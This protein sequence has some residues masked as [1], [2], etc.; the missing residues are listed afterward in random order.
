[1]FKNFFEEKARKFFRCMNCSAERF[2]NSYILVSK[3]GR[4]LKLNIT[5]GKV[6]CHV[7]DGG[8]YW[9]V[10]TIP[11]YDW[12]ID[13][14]LAYIVYFF[15]YVFVKHPNLRWLQIRLRVECF[16]K[17][18]AHFYGLNGPNVFWENMKTS[19]VVYK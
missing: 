4:Y 18:V 9:T 10:G 16:E 12:N 19:G 7:V 13:W 14:M 2:E 1:M 15:D 17:R 11:F 3:T 8:W 6:W 5:N